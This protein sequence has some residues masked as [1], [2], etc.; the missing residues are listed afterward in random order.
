MCPIANA[1][2]AD[3]SSA[4]IDLLSSNLPVV[5]LVINDGGAVGDDDAERSPLT[6]NVPT[7]EEAAYGIDV[8]SWYGLRF[9]PKA[10]PK[11]MLDAIFSVTSDI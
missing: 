11:P 1:A 5:L 2:G 9:A 3:R 7:L 8:T 10:M 6:P 4:G